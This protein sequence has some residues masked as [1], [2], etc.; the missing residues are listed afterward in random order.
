MKKNILLGLVSLILLVLVFACSDDDSNTLPTIKTVELADDNKSAIITF[1]EAVYCNK[2]KT[3][4]LTANCFELSIENVQAVFTLEHQA[5]TATAKVNIQLISQSTGNEKLSVKT[6]ANKVYDA[7]GEA[8]TADKIT[9]SGAIKKS[10]PIEGNW[11]S[12]G[13]NIAPLLSGYFKTDSIYVEFKTD[14]SYLVKEF[15]NGNK[16]NPDITYKGTYSVEKTTSGNIFKI[17]L[18]QTEP[19]VDTSKGIFEIK[20]DGTL[21]YEVVLVTGAGSANTPPTPEAGFGSTNGGAFQTTNIQKYV[22]AQ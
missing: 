14:L 17:V 22:K 18:E 5:G 9:L 10:T 19:T 12:T 4:N 13:A 11:I 8:M 16:G 3:G 7:D 20:E 21:W 2:D 6:I 15:R 1:S